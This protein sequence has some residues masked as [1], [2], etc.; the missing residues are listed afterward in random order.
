MSFRCQRDLSSGH[1]GKISP[2]ATYFFNK[3][4]YGDKFEESY[5]LFEEV[6]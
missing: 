4:E 3:A 5:Y 1:Y 6:L 2:S